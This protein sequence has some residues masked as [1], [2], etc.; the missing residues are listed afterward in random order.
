MTVQGQTVY[1]DPLDIA[2]VPVSRLHDILEIL[3]DSDQDR[4]IR[5]VDELISR[6]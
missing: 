1:A 6:A 4:I 5:A 2:T 3:A